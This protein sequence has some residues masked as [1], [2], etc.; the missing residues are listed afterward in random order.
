MFFHDIFA[1]MPVLSAVTAMV[2]DSV[3]IMSNYNDIGPYSRLDRQRIRKLFVIGL[4][5]GCMAFAGDRLP[6]LS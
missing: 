5:G 4:I 6:T 3:M 2:R 1:I